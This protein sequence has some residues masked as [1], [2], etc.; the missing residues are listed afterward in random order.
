MRLDLLTWPEV[1]AYLKPRPT[2]HPGIILP[3]GSTEQHGPMGLIGTDALCAQAIADG[4]ADKAGAI[5]AP[6]LGYTPAPFNTG[7]PGTMSLSEPV[8]EAMAGE[9][10]AG[11]LEQGFARIYVLNAH[12]ANLAPLRRIAGERAQIRIRSWWDFAPVNALRQ[13]LYGMWE[14]MHATPA[15]VAITQAVHR[16]VAPGA[17][18]DPPEQ[19]SAD[20]IRAHSG[21]KHGPPDEHRARFPDGRVGSHSALATPEDGRRILDAAIW[22]VADDYRDFVAA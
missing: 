6:A 21:D 5:A 11:L 19:L 18:A 4:A 17:A 14:G 8:F 13:A 12:G 9:L 16:V 20:Y 22:S 7:F 3:V 2:A 10:I 1:E 15:E